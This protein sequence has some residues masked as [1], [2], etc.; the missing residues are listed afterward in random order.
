MAEGDVCFTLAS[1]YITQRDVDMGKTMANFFRG[2]EGNIS[3][4]FFHES[5]KNQKIKTLVVLNHVSTT[6][7]ICS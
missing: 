2:M 3:S 6:S 4:S 7:V 1:A 5:K